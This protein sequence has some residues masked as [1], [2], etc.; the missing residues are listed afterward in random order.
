MRCRQLTT[1]K[2]NIN[3]NENNQGRILDTHTNSFDLC[4]SEISPKMIYKLLNQFNQK[5]NLRFEVNM[6]L[7]NPEARESFVNVKKSCFI[8]KE[9]PT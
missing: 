4:F 2:L 1:R 8:N 9:R 6:N 5:S 7:H 3:H